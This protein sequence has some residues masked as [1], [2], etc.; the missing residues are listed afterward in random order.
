MA[1]SVGEERLYWTD[2]QTLERKIVQSIKAEDILSFAASLK[3]EGLI[4][5]EVK[6]NLDIMHPDVPHAR[7]TRYVLQQVYQTINDMEIKIQKKMF[8]SF[9][10]ILSAYPN[11]RQVSGELRRLGKTKQMDG[12]NAMMSLGKEQMLEDKHLG[13][14]CD[15]L[16]R[17]AHKWE[18][19][20]SLLLN[21]SNSVQ[22]IKHEGLGDLRECL[23][24]TFQAWLSRTEQHCL[25][26]TLK[27]LIKVLRS[28][29]VQL[30]RIVDD[31]KQHLEFWQEN[32]S[33]STSSLS[34]SNDETE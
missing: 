23:R 27:N 9:R 17:F 14:L 29:T 26:L 20:A 11:C 5:A 10:K 33:E 19:I 18:G 31:L 16:F 13:P 32:S 28:E 8:K 7:K 21:D 4:S 12:S 1:S 22:C 6:S 24:K 30:S 3:D 25:H 2:I 15:F 34:S